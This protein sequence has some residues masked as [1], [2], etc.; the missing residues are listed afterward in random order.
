MDLETLKASLHKRL[1]EMDE[2]WDGMKA[3]GMHGQNKYF[4]K[5]LLARMSVY[6]ERE[7]E[8][9]AAFKT[10]MDRKFE[11]EHIWAKKFSAHQDEFDQEHEFE[12]CRNQIGGLV[13][14]QRGTNQSYGAKSYQDNPHT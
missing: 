3:F 5:Y 1:H 6:V 10:F 8:I 2:T 14:L 11:V 12:N 9:S 4:I 13:L 7:A